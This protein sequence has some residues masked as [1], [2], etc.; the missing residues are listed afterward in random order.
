MFVAAPVNEAHNDLLIVVSCLEGMNFA[1]G[2]GEE[3][4][5]VLSCV[6]FGLGTF[7]SISHECIQ[8]LESSIFESWPFPHKDL[9]SV[10]LSAL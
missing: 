3:W 5:A 4:F 9:V 8:S 1:I 2:I 7:L 6:R 10:L